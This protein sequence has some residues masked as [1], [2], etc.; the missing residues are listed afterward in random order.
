M[1]AAEDRAEL[2]LADGRDNGENLCPAFGKKSSG[3]AAV[4]TFYCDEATEA[5]CK[6]GE[7]HTLLWPDE[8]GTPPQTPEFTGSGGSHGNTDAGNAP[9]S[10]GENGGQRPNPPSED[11]DSPRAAPTP[12]PAPCGGSST[13][14][15][16]GKK[17]GPGLMASP[18]PRFVRAVR[19]GL[20]CCKR[21]APTALIVR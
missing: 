14:H 15:K 10:R 3:A 19:Y 5:G 11:G 1:T 9:G 18:G 16:R 7:P 8:Y 21:S 12:T 2:S 6:A 4:N 13:G 17:R 20:S